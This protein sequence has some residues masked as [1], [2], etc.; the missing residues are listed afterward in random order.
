MS[1][2]N[3]ASEVQKHISQPGGGKNQGGSSVPLKRE[4][5][6]PKKI[7]LKDTLAVKRYDKGLLA[8]IKEK[9]VYK[10]IASKEFTEEKESLF[11]RMEPH[12]NS[13]NQ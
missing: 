12:K 10:L 11:E 9:E 13:N 8:Q 4:E 7:Q 5:D 2:W 1:H 3:I 6:I